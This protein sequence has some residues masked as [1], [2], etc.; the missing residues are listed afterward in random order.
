MYFPVELVLM[1]KALVTFEGVGHVLLP[2]FDVAEVSRRHMRRVFLEQ[3]SPVRM[4]REG[5]RGTPELVDALVKLPSLVTEGVRVLE[6]STRAPAEHPLTGIRGT[7][8]AGFC[9]VAGAI[10]MAFG[11]PWPVWGALLAAAVLLAFRRGG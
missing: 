2:D 4:I 7:L 3:F 6:R 11:Q 9:L 10:L 8:I 5:L 1:V